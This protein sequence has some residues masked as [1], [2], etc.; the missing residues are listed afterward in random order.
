[1]TL[2]QLRYFLAAARLEHVGKAARSVAISPSAVS[3]AISSLES[4]LGGPLFRRV[5]KT[6]ALNERGQFLRDQAQAMFVQ[7]DQFTRALSDQRTAFIG[8][9]RI[10]GSPFL[11]A[12]Y[13]APAVTRLQRDSP[14]LTADIYGF[15]TARAV[16]A[17]ADGSLDLAICFSPHRHAKLSYRELYRGSLVLA[18]RK[19]HPALG[20][21]RSLSSLS[22]FPATIHRSAEGVEPCDLHPMFDRLDIRPRI[23]CGFDSDDQ[24]IESLRAS[25]AWSLLP[26][27]VVAATRQIVALPSPKQWEA[28]Y[29][30]AALVPPHR[31][32]D[33]A[34]E[35]LIA[36]IQTLLK[37][38]R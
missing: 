13:L 24:A 14:K 30:I 29:V 5:G 11:A 16:G 18:V 31:A 17:L 15:A 8:H 28:P 22:E 37:S 33:M 27:V 21:G 23:T 19:G 9:L 10:G 4:E 36:H 25:D 34:I 2:D 26:D 20:K 3:H 7:L 12:H 35:T 32:S 1:M 6:I 38:R